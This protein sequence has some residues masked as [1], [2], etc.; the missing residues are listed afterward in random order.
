MSTLT[1]S[2]DCRITLRCLKQTFEFSLPPERGF[3]SLRSDNS[4]IE[5]FF[6]RREHDPR[7]GEGGERIRQITSRPAF[8]L[9]SGRMRGA[10]WL[11][12]GHPPQPIVWLLGAEQ[13]DERH[14]GHSDAYDILGDLDRTGQLW[15]QPIDY[16][17]LELDRRQWDTSSFADDLRRDA[18]ALVAHADGTT[19]TLAGVPVRAIA[20]EDSSYIVVYVAVSTRP[21]RG[22][23]SGLEFPLDQKRFTLLMEGVR[24][25]C[26][27]RW[28][29]PS[30]CDELFDR[31]Q[32]PG[33]TAGDERA[34]VVLIGR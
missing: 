15:P 31:T 8:K 21:V 4:L 29:P 7:G 19:H 34:F 12:T 22:P 16:Q 26:E 32:F 2:N 27:A 10:T 18:A 13:H 9:T 25:A 24:E 28:Q 6:D 20:T 11:D 23:R 14:K 1:R 5:A 3:A 17:R 33:P 30:L